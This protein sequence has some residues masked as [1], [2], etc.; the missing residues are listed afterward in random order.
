MSQKFAERPFAGTLLSHAPY[1]DII[2]FNALCSDAF[3][4]VL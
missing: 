3:P 4:K 1:V 2:I